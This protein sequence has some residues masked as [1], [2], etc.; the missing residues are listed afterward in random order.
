MQHSYMYHVPWKADILMIWYTNS[1][2]LLWT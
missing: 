1:N 2:K